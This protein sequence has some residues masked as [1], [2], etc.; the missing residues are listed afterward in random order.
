[1]SVLIHW[2][3]LDPFSQLAH[4]LDELE[5]LDEFGEGFLP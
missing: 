3:S 1:M 2:L 5:E 4:S